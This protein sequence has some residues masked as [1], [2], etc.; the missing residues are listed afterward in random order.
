[1]ITEWGRKAHGLCEGNT[2]IRGGS[3]GA[4]GVQSLEKVIARARIWNL[5]FIF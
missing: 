2:W 5:D 3:C 1:M 4:V